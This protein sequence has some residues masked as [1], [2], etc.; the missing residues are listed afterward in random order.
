MP[1]NIFATD[2]DAAPRPPLEDVVA[3]FRSGQQ[4]DGRPVALTA[5]RVTTGDP[6][7]ADALADLLGGEVEEWDTKSE[8]VLE[9][10]TEAEEV[11]IILDGPGAIRSSMV[12]WGRN[13]KV[14]ECDGVTQAP[15]PKGVAAPC[16]CPQ[17]VSERK[18][19]AQAGWGCEPSVQVYFRLADA[20][21]LGRMKFFSG[22]WSLAGRIGDVEA[23]LA[24]ID[25][26]AKGTLGLTQIT[27]KAGRTFTLP[28]VT[29]LGPAETDDDTPED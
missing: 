12:L 27:T 4:I 24:A 29:I 16:V 20:P 3:R 28:V 14:R 19:A 15:D 18:E 1:I 22:S 9:V 2:P 6:D 10:L 11:P 26:P 5:W 23:S 7:V 21:D 13:G 17:K 25:G 8:E